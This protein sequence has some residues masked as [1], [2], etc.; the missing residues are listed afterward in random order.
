MISPEAQAFIQAYPSDDKR[1][2]FDDMD[3]VRDEY[4]QTNAAAAERA[5][6]RHGLEFSEIELGGVACDR[7]ISRAGI[8]NG[9]LFYVFGGA[10]IAGDPYSDLPIVGALAELCR[11]EVIAPRY[12]LAPESPA[13]AA[14]HDCLGAYRALL[15]QSGE[16]RMVM[17]GESAGGNLA[18]VTAQAAVAEGLH[19]PA[20][21]ALLS[22]AVDMRTDP[23]LYAPTYGLDPTLSPSRMDDVSDVY[24][25][26]FDPLDPAVSPLFGPM[27]GM[28][29][30][31]ITTG[32]RDLF[33]AGCLRLERKMRRAGVEVDCRVW[34][35]MWHVFE[36]YDEY[37]EAAESLSEVAHF[38]EL[39]LRS[40]HQD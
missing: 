13:P 6:E 39:Q 20:A 8:V 24:V 10:F 12:R 34:D 1:A 30:T 22:P 14:S 2:D 28:P 17:A 18:L 23:Q 29:P 35:G 19:P 31:I 21:L 36:F 26:D 38:L 11:V 16:N 33:L 7:I 37:P 9:H 5:I 27:E 4:R 32:T 15:A 25:V 40:H 3:G